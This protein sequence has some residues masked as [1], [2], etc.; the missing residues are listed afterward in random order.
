MFT[1]NATIWECDY[2]EYTCTPHFTS[3]YNMKK[4]KFSEI[5]I[6]LN[7]CELERSHIPQE[8]MSS[9]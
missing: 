4:F 1:M 7:A 3:A 8:K 9:R 5:S 6:V 2:H